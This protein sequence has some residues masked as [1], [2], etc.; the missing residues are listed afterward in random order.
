MNK[1]C[2]SRGRNVHKTAGVRRGAISPHSRNFHPQLSQGLRG[3][4]VPGPAGD[5]GLSR[6]W[7]SSISYY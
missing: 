2:A 7:A 6:R 5:S 1:L 3:A 4:Q